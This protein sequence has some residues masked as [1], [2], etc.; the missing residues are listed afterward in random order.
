M[1]ELCGVI[2]IVISTGYREGTLNFDLSIRVEVK[3]GSITLVDLAWMQLNCNELIREG[4]TRSTQ[5]QL[6]SWESSQRLLKGRGT[7]RSPVSRWPAAGLS[8]SHW[9]LVRSPANGSIWKNFLTFPRR[10]CSCFIGIMKFKSRT[11]FVAIYYLKA[12]PITSNQFI[13]VLDKQF[14]YQ[15]TW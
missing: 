11:Y 9:L 5:L 4:R 3:F 15:Y 14:P 1:I 2:R 12:F 10:K 6:E 8:D 7:P 13:F